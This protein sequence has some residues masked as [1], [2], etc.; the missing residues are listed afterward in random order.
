MIKSL[1]FFFLFIATLALIQANDLNSVGQ[2]PAA[3]KANQSQRSNKPAQ[4]ARQ[5]SSKKQQQQPARQQHQQTRKSSKKS[6]KAKYGVSMSSLTGFEKPGMP[7]KVID[8]DGILPPNFNLSNHVID[9]PQKHH[10]QIIV[11]QEGEKILNQIT[12]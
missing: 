7:I 9:L 6:N 8:F 10:L 3:R 1:L 5:G 4:V 11:D 2:P 12:P